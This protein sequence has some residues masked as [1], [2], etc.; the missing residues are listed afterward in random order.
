MAINWFP[1]HMVAAVE[2]ATKAMADND[3]VVEVL[4]A[5]CP[6]ACSNPI[7]HQMRAFRQRPCL[8]VLNKADI[9]DPVATR[10]WLDHFNA[11]PGVKAIAISCKKPGDAVKVTK[12]AALLAPHRNTPLKPLRMLVMGIPNVGKST[13]INALLKKRSAKVG[14]E[15][16][17]TK[18][19]HRYDVSS[20]ITLTDTPGLMWPNIENVDHGLMLA[21][22]HSIGVKAYDEFE[23]A[24][25]LAALLEQRYPGAIGQRYALPITAAMPGDEMINA[26]A[27]KRGFWLKA[28]RGLEAQLDLERAASTFLVDYRS[29]RLG[30]LSLESPPLATSQSAD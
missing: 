5:R 4:D 16:A 26:I 6:T 14:D 21:A 8:K 24:S 19:L 18:L 7:I 17:V 15:P 23:V 9:S 3:L 2:K 29:A 22:S 27:A 28:V 1:G 25:F 20:S 10:Q 12:A 13:L 11:M 30:M